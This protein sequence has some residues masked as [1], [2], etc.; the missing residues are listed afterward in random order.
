MKSM[1]LKDL[2]NISHNARSMALTMTVL[3]C[4]LF[5]SGIEGYLAMSIFMFSMMIAT[6]FSF[7]DMSKWNSYALVMPVGKK[8]VVAAKFVVLLLFCTAGAF[9]GL[10]IGSIAGI[11]IPAVEF[12]TAMLLELLLYTPIYILLGMLY[13]GL[14]IPLFFRYGA[15]K[16]RT[17]VI[18]SAA[19]IVA[20]VLLVDFI[21][22]RFFADADTILGVLCTAAALL[23][24][25]LS[26]R[27]SCSIFEK[28]DL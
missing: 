28:K 14:C 15:E 11:L 6:T 7:D 19:V 13:G 26:Y 24:L 4:T 21:G 12:S 25:Y 5:S 2:Y 27:I 22:D 16:A 3:A 18:F 10:G 23:L 17:L 8:Q 1:I 9:W 20:L